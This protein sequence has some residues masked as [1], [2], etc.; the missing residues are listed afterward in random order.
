MIDSRFYTLLCPIFVVY[1]MPT[2]V[3]SEYT[4][5]FDE[6]G[7]V[8]FKTFHSPEEVMAKR[9]TGESGRCKFKST[10]SALLSEYSPLGISKKLHKFEARI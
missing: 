6:L 2:Q 8:T 3:T 5:D 9:V 4:A 7:K 1:G 10:E